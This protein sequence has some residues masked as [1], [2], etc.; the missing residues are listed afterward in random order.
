MKKFLINILTA[1]FIFIDSASVN[2]IS[3]DEA[4]SIALE[5]NPSLNQTRK[6]IDTATEQ[7][8]I[9]KGQKGFTLSLS[10]NA[11]ATKNEGNEETESISNRISASIP[12]Y[13]GGQLEN[14]IKAADLYIKI[15]EMDFSQSVDDLKYEVAVAYIDALENRATHLVDIE[16]RDNLATHEQLISDL[17]DAGSKA[18]IDYLRAQ[19]ETSDAHQTAI[20][21]QTT[22]EISLNKLATLLSVEKID[23]V[24][25]IE[26]TKNNFDEIDELFSFAMEKR[27]DIKS[28]NLKIERGKFQ[29]KSAKSG[30]LPSVN[31][32]ASTGFNAQSRDWSPTSNAT[33]GLSASWNIFDSHVTRA[34]VDE[35]KIEIEKLELA[36]KSDTNSVREEL[37]DAYK[38]LESALVRLSTTQAAVDLAIEERYIATEKYREGEGILLDILDAEVSLSTAKKN[39]V[40][41][42]YDV[43]RYQY[44]LKHAMGE[45]LSTAHD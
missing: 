24:E 12:I 34:E 11:D 14:N 37:I 3:L 40:S 27:F 21:S 6:N 33:A 43:I 2:A 15:C 36:L 9:A 26:P 22:Y 16:T 45:T 39:H 28:D 18:K 4:V 20:K 23:D 32:S 35:A 41:A 31:A 10:G 44:A 30:W 5:K 38:N 1:I 17:Y 19:V 42:K 25:E 7:L 8:K 29:L 13:S